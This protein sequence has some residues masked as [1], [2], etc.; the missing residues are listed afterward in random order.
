[1]S[2][3][4][5]H[6]LGVTRAAQVI[7]TAESEEEEEEVEEVEEVEE[8]KE[9]ASPEEVVSECT[10]T[11]GTM[12]HHRRQLDT[13]DLCHRIAAAPWLSLTKNLVLHRF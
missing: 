12:S 9:E 8:E 5:E 7:P 2:N 13:H 10:T 6:H 3:E 4:K 11:A 1:M